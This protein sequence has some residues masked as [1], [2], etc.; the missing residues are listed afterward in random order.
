[1]ANGEPDA[2]LDRGR[3]VERG[4]HADLLAADGRYAGLWAGH[5]RAAGWGLSG[6]AAGDHGSNGPRTTGKEAVR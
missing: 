4:R 2:V 6:H 1:M 3:I 5:D